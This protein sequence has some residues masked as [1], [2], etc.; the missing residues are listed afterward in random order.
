MI[1][2]YTDN[3][4][5]VILTAVF[6]IL[7][8]LYLVRFWK[9]NQKLKVRKRRL[10]WKMMLRSL[11][12]LLFLVALAGPSIGSAMK[13]IK[14]E[15]KDIFLALDL[16]QSM[17]AQDISPSRL[18]RIKFELKNLV[19]NFSSDRIGI[20]IFSS[21]AFIQCPLTFDQ[22]V[23]QLHLDGLN[24]NLVPNYGTDIAA[25]L[26]LAYEKFQADESPEPKSKAI[27]L[28][29]DGEDFGENLSGTLSKLADEGIRVFSLGVGTETGTSIPRG[30]SVVM[31]PKSNRPAV[32]R[33]EASNLK[34][35]ANETSGEY[36]E[37]SDI[38]QE[39]PQLINAVEKLEGTV[40]ASRMVEASANKYF[41]FLLAALIL[42]MIDMM[43]PV[44]TLSI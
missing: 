1:W 40:M 37:L 20:I 33:L 7:Y 21:E 14:Q 36:F 15:G 3:R 39:I 18:Q 22:N 11:Y 5:I 28:I 25:P 12:F 35:I 10:V 17:N 2:A 43:L 32:T 27:I 41:Y 13:E 4:L 6:I 30:S 24:T 16:S 31:D 26:N 42:A 19:K 34:M 29:S 44:R 23:I 8:A 9:I 38:S